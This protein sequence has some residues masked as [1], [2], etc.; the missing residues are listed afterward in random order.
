MEIFCGRCFP[1]CCGIHVLFSAHY[2]WQ[3]CFKKKKK[4]QGLNSLDVIKTALLLSAVSTSQTL[5]FTDKGKET[6]SLCSE[7]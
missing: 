5:K 7:F 4:A 3:R 1:K 6:A 2:R